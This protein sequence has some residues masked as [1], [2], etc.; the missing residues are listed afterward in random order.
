M[1]VLPQQPPAK[2]RAR[3]VPRTPELARALAGEKPGAAAEAT[4]DERA[5][6]RQAGTPKHAQQAAGAPAGVAGQ[7]GQAQQAQQGQQGV[8]GEA[9]LSSGD[10]VMLALMQLQHANK[11]GFQA[12]V[13]CI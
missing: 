6:G 1:D 3:E 13:P 2:K 8:A 4:A 12:C 9:R 11:V 7:A 10:E 5:A